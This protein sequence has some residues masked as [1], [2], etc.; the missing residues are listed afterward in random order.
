MYELHKTIRS[1]FSK[2]ELYTILAKGMCRLLSRELAK[3]SIEVFSITWRRKTLPSLIDKIERKSYNKVSTITDIAGVRIICPNVNSI[4][5][6]FETVLDLFL[7]PEVEDTTKRDGPSSFGYSSLHC[8]S[9]W[10]PDNPGPILLENLHEFYKYISKSNPIEGKRERSG[11]H[12]LLLQ[13]R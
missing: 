13:T 7:V 5:P 9:K 10:K 4:Q 1:Y 2:A 12:I 6:A 8:L 3:R 11:N